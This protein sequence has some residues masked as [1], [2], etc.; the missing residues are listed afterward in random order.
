MFKAVKNKKV[1][2]GFDFDGVITYNPL[3]LLRP[4]IV[5]LKE[6]KIIHRGKMSFYKPKSLMQKIFWLFI[7]QTSSLP[8]VGVFKI[9]R[10]VNLGLIEAFVITGRTKFLINDLVFKLKLFGLHQCFNSI[11]STDEKLQPHQAKFLKIKQLKLDYF[12]E[13]NWDIVQYLNQACLEDRATHCK[14]YWVTNIFDKDIRYQ[15]K[16]SSLSE[17]INIIIGK[18]KK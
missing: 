1:R 13:D 5:F 12:I 11:H 2:V 7:H 9:P 15:Y 6:K 14:V 3:G 17:A 16:A 4:L 10:L 8:S 18:H